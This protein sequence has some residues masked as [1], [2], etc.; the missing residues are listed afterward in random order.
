MT[1]PRCCG[2]SQGVKV[3]TDLEI[4]TSILSMPQDAE[5]W[6]I[7]AKTNNAVSQGVKESRVW[8]IVPW[9]FVY[10][11]TASYASVNET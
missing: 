10:N 1:H 11:N 4:V 5:N 9:I 3:S 8:E 2:V 6:N 7:T